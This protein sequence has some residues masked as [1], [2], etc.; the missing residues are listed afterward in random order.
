MAFEIPRKNA[1]IKV[2]IFT[3]KISQKNGNNISI[4]GNKIA[5]KCSNLLKSNGK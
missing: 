2:P 5:L 3:Q 1:P 4:G